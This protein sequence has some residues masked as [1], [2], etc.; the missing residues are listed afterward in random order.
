M[1]SPNWTHSYSL[2][3]KTELWSKIKLDLIKVSDFYL[4]YDYV[5]GKIISDTAKWYL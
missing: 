4:K 3:S 1:L 5:K 2:K